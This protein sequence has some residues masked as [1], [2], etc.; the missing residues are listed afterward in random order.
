M[1]LDHEV[2]G[3]A[4]SALTQIARGCCFPEILLEGPLETLVL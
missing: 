1:N 2:K 4:G 3:H